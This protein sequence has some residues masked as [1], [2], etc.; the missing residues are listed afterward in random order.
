MALF[1]FFWLSNIPLC[2][3]ATSFLSIHL[4]M[5]IYVASTSGIEA[6]ILWPSDRKSQLIGE[7]NMLLND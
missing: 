4:L 7:K 2:I 6:P 1:H 5:D 3:C